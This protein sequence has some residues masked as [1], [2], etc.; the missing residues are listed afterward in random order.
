V[1]GRRATQLWRSSLR[2]RTLVITLGLTAFAIIGGFVTMALAIQN[3]LFESRVNQV[4]AAV[5]RATATAQDTLGAAQVD[6]DSAALEALMSAV[7][8]LSRG[9]RAPT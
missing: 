4:Q 3:D 5:G 7:L 2:F 6:G 8:T 9:N 1:R